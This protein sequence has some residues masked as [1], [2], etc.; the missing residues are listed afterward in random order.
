M[1][2]IWL[3]TIASVILFPG[4]GSKSSAP[5]FNTP[6]IPARNIFIITID[7]YRW[8]ELFKGAEDELLS[9]SSFCKD[10]E[11]LSFLYR[12]DGPTV[13]RKKLMPFIW[14]VVET[15]GAI[16]GNRDY[17]NKMDVAN[18]YAL[19]YP[20]YSEMLTGTVDMA[21]SNNNKVTN[22]NISILETLNNTYG[23]KDSVVAFSS[24]NLFP[25][26]LNIERS[27]LTVDCG[28]SDVN[29][30]INYSAA[31]ENAKT[32]VG[33]RGDTRADELTFFTA[34]E[35]I[36]IKK[37]RVVFIGF[38]ETDEYAHKGEYDAYLQK[39]NSI[40]RMIGELWYWVQ[41]SPVY[42]NNTTLIIT[43]DHGRG[44]KNAKWTKHGMFIKG[45]SQTWMAAI[46]P[47][48]PALGEV[49]ANMQLYQQQVAQ[50][51]ASVLGQKL[52]TM[53]LK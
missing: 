52:E 14:S 51:V 41:T 16:Y 15:K 5:V 44:S 24:W 47:G 12:G 13:K 8:Q 29:V 39:A 36:K 37:P 1:K 49:K 46:G 35:Y 17:G 21:I 48:V 34:M 33:E 2:N 23:F 53:K 26:I 27:K 22:P 9:N 42:R 7:G 38:G 11:T 4:V 40:D 10:N 30:S 25:F 3:S 45:S 20:G 32:S 19:S 6:A 28:Y 50:T 43:T 18:P 31:L